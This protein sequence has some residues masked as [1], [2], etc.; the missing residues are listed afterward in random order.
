VAGQG[1]HHAVA[2]FWTQCQRRRVRLLQGVRKG[3]TLARFTSLIQGGDRGAVALRA[4]ACAGGG[5]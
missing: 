4:R 3:A 1:E 5:G 2:S